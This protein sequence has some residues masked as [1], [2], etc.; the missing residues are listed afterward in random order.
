MSIE[1][2]NAP[3]IVHNDPNVYYFDLQERT[4][5]HIDSILFY[6]ILKLSNLMNN[7]TLIIYLHT[8]ILPVLINISLLYMRRP[9]AQ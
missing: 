3:P 6:I 1:K 5:V 8:Y 9:H 7:D 4:T 2:V